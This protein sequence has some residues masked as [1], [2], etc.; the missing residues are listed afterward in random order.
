M[1]TQV[2]RY[3]KTN[4]SL[5]EGI[6]KLQERFAAL[7]LNAPGVEG[8]IQQIAVKAQD[9]RDLAKNRCALESQPFMDQLK[10]VKDRWGNLILSFDALFVTCKKA[11]AQ[12]LSNRRQEQDRLRQEAIERL[13]AARLKATETERYD[14]TNAVVRYDALQNLRNA[15]ADVDSLPPSGAPI[16]V[17]TATGTLSSREVT[18]W[19]VTNIDEVPDAYVQRMVDP[20]KVDMAIENG[21]TEIAGIRIYKE[22]GMVSRRPRKSR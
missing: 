13:N 19:Q 3:D 17:K 7:D 14:A 16:G 10:A 20:K 4:A 9:A 18:K 1:D 8:A 15:R 5:T 11:A 6:I 12:V 21:I 22:T 2:V